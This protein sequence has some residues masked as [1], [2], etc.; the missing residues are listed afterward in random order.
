MIIRVLWGSGAIPCTR[1]GHLKQDDAVAHV[2][3]C[4]VYFLVKVHNLYLSG[5]CRDSGYS[6]CQSCQ[7]KRP[8]LLGACV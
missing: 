4:S 3:I 1:H 7:D 6:P 2:S 5:L 8:R